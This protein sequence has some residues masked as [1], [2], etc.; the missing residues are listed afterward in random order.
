MR[1]PD[2]IIEK[3]NDSKNHSLDV[4]TANNKIEILM[5]NGDTKIIDINLRSW[6][7][8]SANPTKI[9]ISLDFLKPVN[10]STG[11]SP[12]LLFVQVFLS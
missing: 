11:F 4:N 2:D 7:A 3:L 8:I 5:I 12:D 6:T 10:V 1:F 9:D